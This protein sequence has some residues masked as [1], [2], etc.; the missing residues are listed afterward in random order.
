MCHVR[1]LDAPFFLPFCSPSFY[2]TY[3]ANE[4][5]ASHRNKL[6]CKV[7]NMEKVKKR[8]EKEVYDIEMS[9]IVIK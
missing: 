5:C 9:S 6:K 4:H 8:G 7:L 3:F 1:I 2:Y